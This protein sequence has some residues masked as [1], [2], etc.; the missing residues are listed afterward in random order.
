MTPT[1]GV[2]FEVALGSGGAVSMLQVVLLDPAGRRL[3]ASQH[4]VVDGRVRVSTVPSGRWELVVQAG[5]SAATRFAVTSPGDQGRF[6]LPTGGVLH[7]RVPELEEEL[8]ATVDLSGPDGKP[9]VP[10]AGAGFRQRPAADE[11]RPGDDLRPRARRLELHR[12]PRGRA[13]LERQRDGDAGIDHRG[14]PALRD[15]ARGG[16]REGRW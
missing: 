10:V 9:F 4:P 5:D 1:E 2:S 14:E 15:P 6:V 16:T 3:A 8:M 12:P 7:L 11:R 13:H